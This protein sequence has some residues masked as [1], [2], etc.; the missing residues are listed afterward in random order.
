MQS[1]KKWKDRYY[2]EKNKVKEHVEEKE[3]I[4]AD[5]AKL[6]RYCVDMQEEK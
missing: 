5:M 2:K 3:T 1:R 6:A 4:L